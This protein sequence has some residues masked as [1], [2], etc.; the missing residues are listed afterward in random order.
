MQNSSPPAAHILL[1]PCSLS[2][3]PH[4]NI[5]LSVCPPIPV[6]MSPISVSPLSPWPPLHSLRSSQSMNTAGNGD[7]YN[8]RGEL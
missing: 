4:P 7:F 5:P 1:S 8:E 2:L 6:P 3:C